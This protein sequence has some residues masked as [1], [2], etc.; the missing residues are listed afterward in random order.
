VRGEKSGRA[1]HGKSHSAST[2]RRQR[3]DGIVVVSNAPSE[4]RVQ[5]PIP[6]P[7]SRHRVRI[8]IP[9]MRAA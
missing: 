1:F 8:K 4:S 2:A 5:F 7:R 6:L 3:N 9:P